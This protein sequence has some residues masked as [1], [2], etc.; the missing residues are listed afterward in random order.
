MV[1]TVAN[2]NI[3]FFIT[4]NLSSCVRTSIGVSVNCFT[5][6]PAQKGLMRNLI[7]MNGVPDPLPNP[8][9]DR[10]A[11]W[12]IES[13]VRR[14]SRP[15]VWVGQHRNTSMAIGIAALAVLTIIAIDAVRSSNHQEP[16]R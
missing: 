6:E 8:T 10:T 12:R 4:K 14:H 15:R 7:L 11:S 2:A 9:E 13:K 3:A 5:R 1:A 16:K